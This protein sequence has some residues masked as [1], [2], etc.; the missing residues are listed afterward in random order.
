MASTSTEQDAG[1][2]KN[3]GLSGVSPAD[4]RRIERAANR[5][6][7][8]P[9]CSLRV[10]LPAPAS[11]WQTALG[12]VPMKQGSFYV[13][14]GAAFAVS[15]V[16]SLAYRGFRCRI[17]KGRYQEAST[18]SDPSFTTNHG[19]FVVNRRTQTLD[20]MAPDGT[21]HL[22]F[23]DIT[24]LQLQH[25]V[26]EAMGEELLF[27]NF[28]LF[29]L[30]HKYRDH[31][32]SYHIVIRTRSGEVPVYESAQYEVRDFLD[33]VTP[34]QLWLLARMGFHKEADAAAGEILGQIQKQLAR[35]GASVTAQR[36]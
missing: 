1:Q 35:G 24:F 17:R 15:L 29:D 11:A 7:A 21:Y 23:R 27:E 34:L 10:A 30:H 33:I 22:P 14:A 4:G 6:L 32:H 9:R 20:I 3:L 5:E 16:L 26:R 2:C 28:S 12:R 13:L 19:T 31:V 36:W 25:R 8:A 18:G